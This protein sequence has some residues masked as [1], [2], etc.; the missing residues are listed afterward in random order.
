MPRTFHAGAVGTFMEPETQRKYF[1]RINYNKD[2]NF[3]WDKSIFVNALSKHYDEKLGNEIS[4]AVQVYGAQDLVPLYDP[5]SI[6]KLTRVIWYIANPHPNAISLVKPLMDE[7]GL[8]HQIMR[9]QKD[10]VHQFW[11]NDNKV[12]LINTFGKGKRRATP[13]FYPYQETSKWIRYKPSDLYAFE[14]ND[15]LAELL[16]AK[17]KGSAAS[18]ETA[19]TRQLDSNSLRTTEEAGTPQAIA[20]KPIETGQSCTEVCRAVNRECSVEHLKSLNTCD[21]LSQHFSCAGCLSSVGA[22]QP[23][24]VGMNCLVNSDE[25]YFSCEGHYHSS[26]RLCACI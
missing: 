1:D 12:I 4:Q 15:L 13:F 21:A 6:D 5:S 8:W 25:A 9:G 22:D 16:K 18:F 19:S 7:L 3:R 20:A 23:A 24:F 2:V 26:R 10:G 17:A 11:I 14:P